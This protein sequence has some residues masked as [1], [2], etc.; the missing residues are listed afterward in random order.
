MAASAT[1]HPI[2]RPA[3][4]GFLAA[5]LRTAIDF[6]ARTEDKR[7]AAKASAPAVEAPASNDVDLW[8]LYWAATG[9]GATN[10]KVRAML[11]RAAGE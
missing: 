11:Q 10:Q 5:L 7:S 9:T 2:A 8:K 3:T 6:L 1:T 4:H